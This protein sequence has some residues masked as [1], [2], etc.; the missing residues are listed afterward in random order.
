[1]RKFFIVSVLSLFFSPLAAKEFV[2]KE[3]VVGTTSGYAP[4]VSLDE[5]G[6]YVGFDIDL[7]T[8]LSKK[9]QCSL[10]IKDFGSMP[11]LMLALQQEKIDAIIWAVSI[12]EERQKQIEMIYYQGEKVTK[13]PL[14]F[15]K[16]I[17]ENVGSLQD[18][19]DQ[20]NAVICVEAG[21]FQDAILQKR[22]GLT[23]KHVDTV[24]D[25]LL[26]IRYGKSQ[27]TLV[28]PS[29]VSTLLAKQPE[30]KVVDIDLNP[31][32]QSLG[33]GI[34]LKKNSVLIEQVRLAISEMQIEGKIQELEKKWK[35][36]QNLEEK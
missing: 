27:A 4:Y 28:D 22:K 12:T 17:P 30:L 1:M 20:P 7:A 29:L 25:A 21:S 3:F 36:D 34:C 33:N 5:K 35:L 8:I 32:E 23:V 16:K 15:W 18:L 10:K 26:E 2:A 24:T 31:S 19:A 11:A 13:L 6:E 9:L 14:L